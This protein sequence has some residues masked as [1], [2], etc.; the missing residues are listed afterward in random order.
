MYRRHGMERQKQHFCV[1]FSQTPYNSGLGVVSFFLE[2]FCGFIVD[3]FSV[4]ALNVN[5]IQGVMTEIL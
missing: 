2:K 5:K 3:S 4:P 1:P